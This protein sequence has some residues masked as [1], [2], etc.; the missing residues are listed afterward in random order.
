MA[1]SAKPL[2]VARKAAAAPPTAPKRKKFAEDSGLSHLLSLTES[3]VSAKT[4]F[5]TKQIQ[6]KKSQVTAIQQKKREDAQ[7]RKEKSTLQPGAKGGGA[8]AGKVK[9]KAEIKM[10]LKKA[11]RGKA[12]ARKEA[13]R[14]R[15]NMV[16][17]A[18]QAETV[19]E[20]GKGQGQKGARK[21]V[22][23]AFH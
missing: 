7:R 22:S 13:R 11:L 21:S 23:F 1:A 3:I 18:V 2:K 15:E 6:Q 4:V 5:Q 10:E 12:K 19:G 16:D 8:L 20:K 14:A 9:S 17:G